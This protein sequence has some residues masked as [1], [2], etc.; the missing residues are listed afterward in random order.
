VAL[1]GVSALRSGNN[2]GN[3]FSTGASPYGA[4][5]IAMG[6]NALSANNADDLVGG[7]NSC[8][9]IAM[10]FGVARN[11]YGSASGSKVQNNV[12]IGSQIASTIP[13]VVT[14][15]IGGQCNYGTSC[16]VAIG[17][18][19]LRDATSYT[20]AYY[21]GCGNPQVRRA[22]SCKNV[23]IGN[24]AGANAKYQINN[25]VIG[26]NA[27]C[28][29]TLYT[30]CFSNNN[31]NNVV[32][33][34]AACT[35][36][37]RNVFIGAKATG[38]TAG[39]CCS[40]GV[41]YNPFNLNS[42]TVGS[43]VYCSVAIGNNA[44]GNGGALPSYVRSSSFDVIIGHN[45]GKRL[46]GVSTNNVFIGQRM[47]STAQGG[48]IGGLSA[49]N[50]VLLGSGVMGLTN[51]NG[52]S[53]AITNNTIVGYKAGVFL[54]GS[55]NIMIG[56]CTLW[57]SSVN[58]GFVSGLSGTIV[59]GTSAMPTSHNQLALAS[60]S[61]PL[62]TTSTAGASQNRFL[63]VNLNGQIGKIQLFNV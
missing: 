29:A 46:A 57:S 59:I 30:G 25:V 10:G 56:A 62:S 61:I 34:Y 33:G 26:H 49:T 19:A 51:Y 22:N 17:H 27:N 44:M 16:N 13:D 35:K 47:L 18:G 40:I 14:G 31:S 53:R 55:N 23:V 43:N 58:N 32:I 4:N 52:G 5:T 24:N 7:A 11:K 21:D 36:G 38:G 60:A 37:Y 12:F 50:N 20:N 3:F 39:T 42:G 8:N 41:G 1:S 45:I 9:N 63:V 28:F 54:N 6:I 2:A 15:S 48:N